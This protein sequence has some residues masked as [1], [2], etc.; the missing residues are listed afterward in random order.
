M[1]NVIILSLVT[2]LWVGC[3]PAP[4]NTEV[5][6]SGV[7]GQLP[8]ITGPAGRVLISVQDNLWEGTLDSIFYKAFSKPAPGPFISAEP[9]FDYFQQDPS[10]INQLGKKNRNFL[11]IILEPTANFEETEVVIKKNHLADGQIY[12]VVKDND[13]DRLIQF[14]QEQLPTYIAVFNDQENERLI[15]KYTY[16]RHAAFDKIAREKFGIGIGVPSTA[17]FEADLDSIIY[18]LDKNSKEFADNPKTKAKGGIYWAKKGILIWDSPYTDSTDMLPQALLNNRDSTLKYAVKGTIPNSYMATE[19][20]K[21][22]APKFTAVK[23]G[24]ANAV[25][26]E[27]LWKH[28]GNE[29]ASGGGPFVE[30]ALYHSTRN[31]I[32]H[33]STYIYALNFEKRELL[34]EVNAILSTV[35]V[36]D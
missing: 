26:I 9:I 17:N 1:K 21:T 16:T 34:R 12:M 13:K 7:S 10:E 11:S 36:V 25:K 24:E 15:K 5:I 31:R 20:Y 4:S 19:Y 29:A 6:N 30:V 32:I 14:F 33:V 22:H 3:E 35:E 23:V 28:A 27:G 18:A 2:F 8:K